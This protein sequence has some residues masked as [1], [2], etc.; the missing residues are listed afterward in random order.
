M[1]VSDIVYGIIGLVVSILVIATILLPVIDSLQIQDQ[2]TLTLFKVCGTLAVLV[3]VMLAVR[4]I[5][6]KN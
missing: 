1:D 5:T 4:M 3:P 6:Y 2:T